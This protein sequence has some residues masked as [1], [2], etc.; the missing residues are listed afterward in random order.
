M[1]TEQVP[2]RINNI[3]SLWYPSCQYFKYLLLR[4]G[5]ELFAEGFNLQKW[6]TRYNEEIP[7][8]IHETKDQI[9][10]MVDFQRLRLFSLEKTIFV[11]ICI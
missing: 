9:F 7:H 10:M 4:V 6:N 3:I 8:K 2:F 11:F 1:I 5:T